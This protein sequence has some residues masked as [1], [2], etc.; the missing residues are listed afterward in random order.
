MTLRH[1]LNLS[2]SYNLL[3]SGLKSALKSLKCAEN[4]WLNWRI[5]VYAFGSVWRSAFG[6]EFS[7]GLSGVSSRGRLSGVSSR[8]GFRG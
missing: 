3:R 4:D 1:I 6:G 8:A 2:F 5:V 7:G